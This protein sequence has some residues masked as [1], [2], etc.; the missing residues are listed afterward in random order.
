MGKLNDLSIRVKLFLGFG[1]VCIFFIIVG[2]V[3]N[4]FNNKTIGELEVTKSEVLPHTLSFIEIKRDIE[5]I[6]QWL[7]DISAT[8]AE[9]GY[10]DGYAEAEIYY[11][12]AVKRIDLSIIEHNKYGEA[13][14]VAMLND[15]KKSLNDYYT[16]GKK[17]AQAYIEGGPEKGN[18]MMG[19]FDPFAE[20]LAGIIDQIVDEHKEELL[21]SF[22]S[23]EAHSISNT[24]TATIGIIA[25]LIFSVLTAYGISQSIAGSLRKAVDFA[26][27]VAKGNFDQTLVIKQ[28]DEVGSLADSLNQ[29]SSNLKNLIMDMKDSTITV[30]TSAS[31]IKGL[32]DNITASSRDT[33]EKSN[34][35]SAAAEEMSSNMN[36]VASATDQAATSIQT[37]VAAAEEMTAT[38]GE[39]STNISR[40]SETTGHAVEKARQVSVKV[41][42]L[43]SAA[44]QISKVTDT[45]KDISEQTNLLA[46]N[47]TIEAARA[48]EAG[49]G[50]AVVAGEI[51]A[52]AQQ[53]A[54][55]TS[56][57]N[58]RIKSVQSSTEGSVS[59]IQEIVGIINEINEIVNTV[60]AAIEEQSATTQEIS[61]NIAQAGQG[62]RDINENISQASAVTGEIAQDITFV[63]R[64]AQEA[65]QNSDKILE[66]VEDLVKVTEKLNDAVSRFKV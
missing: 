9:E 63:N 15:M 27:Y 64:A 28:R 23:I 36:S 32:S 37:V 59:S 49:K 22:A 8:R 12:D 56:E 7:T 45:I 19:E 53:T 13:E 4:S 65:D 26:G 25:V 61:N 48:G 17:M 62:I 60:S 3:I 55:A 66:D 43:G 14:M 39:I 35:V 2:I 50:F 51:K 1:I 34:T 33:V 54:D 21:N 29:M 41:D 18:P 24:K 11:K 52:L 6:Q 47:A 5:Q 20:K 42:E 44:S 46:L 40:G 57:I 16:M 10:D 38:I 31:T 30:K 58:E